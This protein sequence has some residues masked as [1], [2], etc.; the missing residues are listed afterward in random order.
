MAPRKF[1][2]LMSDSP[3][4]AWS[5]PAAVAST[6]SARTWRM[7]LLVSFYTSRGIVYA[8]DQ[9]ITINQGSGPERCPKQKKLLTTSRLGLSGGV[10]GFFGLAVVG[11]EP[12]ESWLRAA[13]DRWPG[14][15]HPAELGEYLR[16]ELNRSVP[17]PQRDGNASGFHIGAFERRDGLAVP[18]MQHVSNIYGYDPSTSTVYSN[19]GRYQT[20]EHFPSHPNA[21]TSLADV[22]PSGLRQELRRREEETGLPH[23]FRNGELA[24]VAPAWHGL[25]WSINTIRDRLGGRFRLPD[26]LEKWELMAKVLVRTNAD[27]FDLLMISGDPTIE[28]PYDTETIAWPPAITS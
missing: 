7:T 19:Y 20:T 28:G 18:V 11:H 24:F 1:R 8:A 25:T 6:R 2:F 10:V 16:D 3:S 21:A 17:V 23:W 26:D 22:P 27:L 4:T 5:T 15:Q 12:M 9:A 13:L 14:S